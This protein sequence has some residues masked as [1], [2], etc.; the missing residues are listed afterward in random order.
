MALQAG[1]P[2]EK[3]AFAD[4]QELGAWTMDLLWNE[5]MNRIDRVTAFTRKDDP[6]FKLKKKENLK[7]YR[8]VMQAHYMK[9]IKGEKTGNNEERLANYFET[10]ATCALFQRNLFAI[11]KLLVALISHLP[12]KEDRGGIL[13]MVPSPRREVHEDYDD[14]EVPF[15][16]ADIPEGYFTEKPEPKRDQPKAIPVVPDFVP[17]PRPKNQKPEY[18]SFRQRCAEASP[19]D[20]ER[21]ITDDWLYTCWNTREHAH[22]YYTFTD[23]K[24]K[25]GWFEKVPEEKKNEYWRM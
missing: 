10:G 12:K 20:P 8:V 18:P 24:K 19:D 17:A 15:T 11:R 22:G 6:T 25:I 1:L 5:V 21:E 13:A 9:L 4:A 23:H 2:D 16:S 7:G 3:K 14:W